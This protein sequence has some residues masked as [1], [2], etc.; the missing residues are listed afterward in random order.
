IG[1]SLTKS[2]HAGDLDL[3]LGGVVIGDGWISPA[4]FSNS[5]CNRPCSSRTH[6]FW[7]TC[8]GST[9]TPSTMPTSWQRR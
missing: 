7:T 6:G 4:D 2:I 3:T 1:V 5:N 8:R 9:K